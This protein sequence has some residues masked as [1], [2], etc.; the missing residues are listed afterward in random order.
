MCIHTY[1]HIYI[2]FPLLHLPSTSP[3]TTVFF[4]NYYYDMH[5]HKYIKTTC[6]VPLVCLCIHDCRADCLV[7]DKKLGGSSQR[8][9]VPLTAV[10][11]IN[12][13][14]SYCQKPGPC[15]QSDIQE[16]GHPQGHWAPQKIDGPLVCKGL[17]PWSQEANKKTDQRKHNQKPLKIKQ[18]SIRWKLWNKFDR[19]HQILIHW[20]KYTIN[21]CGTCEQGLGV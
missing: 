7:L 2:S 8:R 15:A 6:W 19:S 3:K 13:R 17:S 5:V 9:L 1:I 18:K 20:R 11:G 12:V 10:S 14:E 16:T 4:F 21:V